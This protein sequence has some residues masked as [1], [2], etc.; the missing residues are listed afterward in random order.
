M[1]KQSLLCMALP[2]ML[3]VPGVAFAQNAAQHPA[4]PENVCPERSLCIVDS[5]DQQVAILLGA[6]LAARVF[7]KQAYFF[8]AAAN[9]PPVSAVF[10]YQAQGCIG[11]AYLGTFNDLPVQAYIDDSKVIWGPAAP[12]ITSAFASIKYP[13]VPCQ[14][15]NLAAFTAGAATVL[16][17]TV[18]S[19]W[20]PPF[21][22]VLQR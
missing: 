13:G 22:V 5:N 3:A 17:A 21:R 11:Q 1:N 6:N 10:Y 9:G 16:D 4:A 14:N 2:L 19:T 8:S 20:V 12:F 15:R 18:A 7:N